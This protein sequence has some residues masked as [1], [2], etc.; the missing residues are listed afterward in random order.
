MNHMVVNIHMLI[1]CILTEGM[2]TPET[3]GKKRNVKISVSWNLVRLWP[4]T[5]GVSS[6]GRC[7]Q[8]WW[9]EDLGFLGGWFQYF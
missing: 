7:W 5:S 3:G 1:K 4:A 6:T 2:L 8:W 9:Y